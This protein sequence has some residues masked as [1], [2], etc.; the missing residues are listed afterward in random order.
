M[1]VLYRYSKA[2]CSLK[3]LDRL[4]AGYKICAN[5]AIHHALTD[6]NIITQG[7]MCSTIMEHITDP[8]VVSP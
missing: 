1:C 6:L 7:R 4:A 5:I 2:A 3:P 8:K